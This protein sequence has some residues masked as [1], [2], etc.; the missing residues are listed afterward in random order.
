M[1]NFFFRVDNQDYVRVS[2]LDSPLVA[3]TFYVPNNCCECGNLNFFNNL[4][5]I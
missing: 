1:Y 3:E 2:N 4:F 5:N